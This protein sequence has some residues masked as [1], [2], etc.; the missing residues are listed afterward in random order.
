MPNR[1][2]VQSFSAQVN[3]GISVDIVARLSEKSPMIMGM[4]LYNPIEEH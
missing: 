1:A 3:A 4:E 2:G